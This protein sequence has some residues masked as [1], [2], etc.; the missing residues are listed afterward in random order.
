[1]PSREPGPTADIQSTSINVNNEN[2]IRRG[3]LWGDLPHIMVEILGVIY[4]CL[5]YTGCTTGVMSGALFQTLRTKD[6]KMQVLPAA[7]IIC[8]GALKRQ[9]QRVKY[10]VMIQMKVGTGNH[11]IFFSRSTRFG[12]R[13]YFRFGSGG[14][15]AGDFGSRSSSDEH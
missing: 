13:N 3:R 4:P 8:S 9:K 1:M 10:E 11:D 6:P 15:V 7:G 14:D 2:S 5:A 12:S